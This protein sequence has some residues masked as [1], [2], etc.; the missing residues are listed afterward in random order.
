MPRARHPSGEVDRLA[1]PVGLPACAWAAPGLGIHGGSARRPA[2]SPGCRP[3]APDEDPEPAQ[4]HPPR[5]RLAPAAI[6]SIGR[7]TQPAGQR[8][9]LGTSARRSPTACRTRRRTAAACLAVLRPA[10][11]DARDQP[12]C[13]VRRGRPARLPA[14]RVGHRVTEVLHGRRAASYSVVA[15]SAQG[16]GGVSAAKSACSV[17]AGLAAQ[18]AAVRRAP[19]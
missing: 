18:V 5:A 2:V 3:R 15:R 19:W 8:A 4:D 7:V 1:C 6:G 16:R 11:P 13:H 10:G 9:R 14:P 17:G 12:R